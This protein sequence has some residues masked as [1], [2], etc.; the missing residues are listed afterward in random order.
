MTTPHKGPSSHNWPDG[1]KSILHIILDVIDVVWA[2][3][4]EGRLWYHRIIM[5]PKDPKVRGNLKTERA[6]ARSWGVYSRPAVTVMFVLSIGTILAYRD[7]AGCDFVNFDD[8]KYV[9]ANEQV[10]KG[11]SLE[12]LKWAM[13]DVAVD[14]WH[15]LTWASH[16]LDVSLFGMNAGGHHFVNLV[17]HALNMLLL[18]GLLNYA[19]GRLW[20]SVL[21]A[22]LFAL[23]PL[24]VESV[25]WIAER[26]DVLS[27]FFLMATMWMYVY[28]S[29]RPGWLRYTGIVLLFTLGLMSKPMLVTLP[30][31]L[32]LLD[33][34]PLERLTIEGW[35]VKVKDGSLRGLLLE[36]V[37]LA[38]MAVGTAALT[39]IGQRHVSAMAT[40]E[41][42]S[43]GDRFSNALVSYWRYIGAMFWPEGLAALYLWRGS[44]PWW[45]GAMALA[46]LAAVTGVVWLARSRK[47]VVTGWLWYLVT[48]VPVIGLVQVGP[49]TH[50]DRYTYVPLTGLFV[51]IAWAAAEALERRRELR[52]PAAIA[53]VFVLAVAG[54]LTWKTVSYWKDTETLARRAVSVTNKNYMMLELLGRTQIQHGEFDAAYANLM[55]SLRVGTR[56][57]APDSWVAVAKL[58]YERGQ[59]VEAANYGTAALEARP[60]MKDAWLITGMALC[61]MGKFDESEKHLRKA[62]ELGG[63]QAKTYAALGRLMGETN[64]V[65]E[66]ISLYRKSLELERRDESVQFNLGVLCAIKKEYTAAAEAY[67]ASFALK[68]GYE[69]L[70][71]L[72]DCMV[73]LG[74]LDDAELAYRRSIKFKNDE[75]VT[76]Y[77]LA[78]VLASSGRTAEAIEEARTTMKLSP[79]NADAAGLYRKLTGERQ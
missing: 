35:K 22:G 38:A 12:G 3:A 37:P 17:F 52:A 28:Y 68:P 57:S 1:I 11:L 15:P 60:E 62:I 59:F 24:H 33:Y 72:G 64:R 34:W 61:D 19:T 58:L 40:M 79:D 7:L 44:P 71:G 6:P 29:R 67:R 16:M 26:K 65:D 78:L 41:D 18:F 53:G 49:Q 9:T 73:A 63:W 42:L 45:Q 20:A 14:Y 36:K 13:T 48:L 51:I 66:G 39:I 25:A 4:G 46:G 30:V 54:F 47:Y 50:A 55:E 69:A 27:T 76:H 2:V 23:H 70:N 8:P 43:I 5:S 56:N 10:K 75:A 77:N 21:V 74:R 32:V 31:V